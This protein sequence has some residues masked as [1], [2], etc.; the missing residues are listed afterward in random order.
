M[1]GADILAQSVNARVVVPDF[2]RGNYFD[3]AWMK[4]DAPPEAKEQMQQWIAETG[5]PVKYLEEVAT[6][7]NALKA[8]GAKKVALVGFCW[9]E[10]GC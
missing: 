3:I 2:I 5:N 4:P 9:G 6:V 1:Q 8:A 10:R 7:A